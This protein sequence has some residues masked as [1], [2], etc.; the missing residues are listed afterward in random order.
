MDGAIQTGSVGRPVGR[1]HPVG[2]AAVGSP[3]VG[4]RS[5]ATWPRSRKPGGIVLFAHGSGSSRHSPRNPRVAERLQRGLGTL[6][7]DL[8][9]ADEEEVDRRSRKLR[10]DS[11]LLFRRLLGAVDCLAALLGSGELRVGLF[12]ASTDAAATQLATGHR[13]RSCPAPDTCSKSPARSRRSPAWPP[14]G[15]SPSF[16]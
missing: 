4:W 14:P 15:S 12:D 13:L 9:T 10:F 11:G 1:P 6:P 3:S 5:A 2:E 16:G 7:M 8:L